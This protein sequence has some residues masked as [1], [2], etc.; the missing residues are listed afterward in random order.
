M[1]HR[2]R[3]LPIAT[4]RD[5]S[6]ACRREEVSG[7]FETFNPTFTWTCEH[8]LRPNNGPTRAIDVDR[9]APPCAAIA[10]LVASMSSSITSSGGFRIAIDRGVGGHLT[11]GGAH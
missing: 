5:W 3:V 6:G 1:S 7:Q 4:S 8:W 11:E 2:G 10:M 9:R